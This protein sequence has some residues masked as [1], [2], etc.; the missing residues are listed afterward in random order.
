MIPSGL[1]P[2][3]FS[4]IKVDQEMEEKFDKS[5]VKEFQQIEVPQILLISPLLYLSTPRISE[6]QGN[7]LLNKKLN[8]DD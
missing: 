1:S 8:F 6:E 3:D 4:A 7:Y 2:P 5:E